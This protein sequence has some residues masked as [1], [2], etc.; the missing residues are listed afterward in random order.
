MYTGLLQ[1]IKDYNAARQPHALQQKYKAMAESPFRFFRGTAHLFY[2]ALLDEYA[3]SASPQSWI[4]G[5]LHIENFGCYRSWNRSLFFDINDFD[6]AVLAPVLYELIRLAASVVLAADEAG[7]ERKEKIQWVQTLLQ[8][9]RQTL[10]AGIPVVAV[11]NNCGALI[12]QVLD[13]VS[14]RTEKQLLDERIEKKGKQVVLKLTDRLLP[15][16]DDDKEPFLLAFTKWFQSRH[17]LPH[18][19]VDAGLRLSGTAGL[20]LLRYVVLLVNPK[21]GRQKLLLDVKQALASP[22]SKYIT[23]KQPRWLNEADRIVHIQHMMQH[24]NPHLLSAFAYKKYSFVVRE[25]QPADD[26]VKW[27]SKAAQPKPM[28]S[29][30]GTLGTLVASAQMRVGANRGAA[31]AG[32]LRKFA[33]NDNWQKPL[34]NWVLSYSTQLQRQ[35]RQYVK[36]YDKGF[37]KP[38]SK[39][40]VRSK[41]KKT[42]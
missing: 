26:K 35:Y 27:S 15:M 37:F 25:I 13:K 19:A 32:L 14:R 39:Q 18:T 41:K 21:D 8:Q 4:C 5:D 38:V 11:R 40:P 17:K 33:L 31:D 24:A 42:A 30:L 23:L 28:E 1:K 20:G 7:L 3:F 29:F 9:Y 36:A 16:P 2:E 6:D 10:V 22:V 12:R 34:L